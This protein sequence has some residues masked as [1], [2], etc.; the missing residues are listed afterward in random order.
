MLESINGVWRTTTLGRRDCRRSR[1]A[2]TPNLP[3]P[4]DRALIS[5]S[6]SG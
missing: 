6:T 5:V 1:L 3:T 4:S 2:C